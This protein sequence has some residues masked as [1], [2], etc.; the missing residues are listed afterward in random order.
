LEE[1]VAAV[2]ITLSDEDLRRIEEAA[3]KG[4]ASGERYTDMSTVN[5]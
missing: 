3:P 2:E 1:N 5:R 4:A